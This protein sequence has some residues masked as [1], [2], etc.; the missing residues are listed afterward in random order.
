MRAVARELTP[1]GES[2]V[3]TRVEA[4]PRRLSAR[5][6]ERR[7]R[8]YVFAR[9]EGPDAGLAERDIA[10]GIAERYYEGLSAPL[11]T[12][13]TQSI[14]DIHERIRAENARY[15]SEDRQYGALVCLVLHESEAYFAL[16]GTGVAYALTPDGIQ[17]VPP[18]PAEASLAECG[19]GSEAAL[20]I[21]LYRYPLT[22]R[23][24]FVLG[25][26]ILHRQAPPRTL[27]RAILETDLPDVA[28]VLCEVL[29]EAGETNGR[30]LVVDVD[31]ELPPPAPEP[32]ATP[33]AESAPSEASEGPPTPEP[34][35][36]PVA[37]AIAPQDASASEPPP[38]ARPRLGDYI[39]A[40]VAWLA[41]AYGHLADRL[42]PTVVHRL[43]V[44]VMALLVIVVAFVVAFR[45][46]Q[47]RQ[48]AIADADTLVW[49]ER[50][51]REA[52]ATTDPAQRI[53]LLEDANS[54]AQRAVRVRR[55]DPTPAALSARVQS[56]L[57]AA[58]QVVRLP[59]PTQMAALDGDPV[60]L[61]Y[62]NGDLYLLNQ[63]VD[64]VYRFQLD[65]TGTGIE[66]QQNPVVLRRGDRLGEIWL[67][68]PRRLLWMPGG[69]ARLEDSL[70]VFDEAGALVTYSPASGARPARSPGGWVLDHPLA[71][72]AGS[73]FVLEARTGIVRW[74][75]PTRD[76]Y[77]R[78]TYDYLV[79]STPTAGGEGASIAVDGDVYVLR[80]SGRIDRYA[81]GRPAAFDGRI[82]DRPLGPRA[83]LLVQPGGLYAFDP[84][85]RR[86]VQF[87]REGVFQRQYLLGGDPV[88]S[89]IALDE[90]NG[91]LYLLDSVGVYFVSLGNGRR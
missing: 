32:A 28:E 10:R 3:A 14:G 13:L 34:A 12:A 61:V 4:I 58:L 31:P 53:K 72:Y 84:A 44:G 79:P 18:T 69:S 62:G 73:I 56:E 8:L 46:T 50:R 81:L 21:D 76:G 78:E 60:Q 17:S 1:I 90:R 51:E 27:W 48:D 63:A 87:S 77:D 37:V 88:P 65:S 19:L 15:V 36:P 66:T 25:A 33:E 45:A 91:L 54:L 82:P 24:A 64:R 42:T 30:A 59:A 85:N 47:G 26:A 74:I 9:V 86:I 57:D 23:C 35:A 41:R 43:V 16:V 71:G 22:A 49:A 70:L 38:W 40:L 89:S 6:T 39:V 67:E 20:T 11:T 52:L 55:G 2:W 75:A 80:V 7:G 68:R 83:S 29:M 5:Q